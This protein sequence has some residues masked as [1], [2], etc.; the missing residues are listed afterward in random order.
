MKDVKRRGNAVC[1]QFWEKKRS[2]NGIWRAVRRRKLVCGNILCGR[3]PKET[4]LV[5]AVDGLTGIVSILVG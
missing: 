4:E 3:P 1:L 5:L 2:N